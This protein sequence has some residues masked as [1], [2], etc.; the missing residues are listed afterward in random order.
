MT[1]QKNNT[2]NLTLKPITRS[3]YRQRH[4]PTAESVDICSTNKPEPPA[5]AG[6]KNSNQQSIEEITD[7]ILLQKGQIVQSFIEIGHLLLKAKKLLK[8]KHGKWRQWL[9]CNVDISER[10]AERHMQLAKAYGNSTSVSGLGMT[11]ALILLELPDEDRE[12]F[13]NDQ[14]EVNGKMLTVG[15]MSTRETRKIV[16]DKCRPVVKKEESPKEF[17]PMDKDSAPDVHNEEQDMSSSQVK[18]N[19]YEMN[20]VKTYLER[21]KSLLTEN[22]YDVETYDRMAEDMRSLQKIISQ[23][24]VLIE[25]KKE[26]ADFRRMLF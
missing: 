8:I 24:I 15:E 13:I 1:E 4:D 9:K 16:H 21:T 26:P 22:K 5:I 19:D 12:T 18:E 2:S 17:Q 11:K 6:L 3:T 25:R 14:H 7:M 20:S 10:Q 23:C